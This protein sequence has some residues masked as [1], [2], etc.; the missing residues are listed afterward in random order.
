MN[1]S[2]ILLYLYTCVYTY[3][4]T[5]RCLFGIRRLHL[6]KSPTR[7]AFYNTRLNTYPGPLWARHL[8]PP[9]WAFDGRALV[10]PLG[11]LWAG[12]LWVPL[13]PCGPGPCGLPWA[14][15]GRALVGSPGPL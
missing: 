4:H 3:T 13:G 7:V 12:R 6:S 1:V 10:G 14:L 5:W 9:P 2:I 8:W 11:P 15:V